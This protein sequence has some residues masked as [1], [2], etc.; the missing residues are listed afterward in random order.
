MAHHHR[1]LLLLTTVLLLATTV[2][3]RDALTPPPPSWNITN[4]TDG[5]P[6]SVSG[7]FN[8]L[9]LYTINSGEIDNRKSWQKIKSEENKHNSQLWWSK[10]NTRDAA[11]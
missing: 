10:E 11:K 5:P 3:S 9:S 6:G 8:G 1:H 7:G 4:G 2:T